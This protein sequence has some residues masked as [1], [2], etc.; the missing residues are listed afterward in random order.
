[1]NSCFGKQVGAAAGGAKYPA[2]VNPAECPNFPFCH[3]GLVGNHAVGTYKSAGHHSYALGVAP[4][5]LAAAHGAGVGYAARYPAGV[6]PEACPNYPY[7]HNGYY[8][9]H[10]VAARHFY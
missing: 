2:G 4:A 5:A 6:N 9:N 8:G 7:C 10:A 3:N 1:L